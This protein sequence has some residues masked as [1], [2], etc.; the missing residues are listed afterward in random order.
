MDKSHKVNKYHVHL[1]HTRVEEWVEIIRSNK[2][3]MLTHSLQA[4]VC[5][6]IISNSNS[7]SNNNSNS[8]IINLSINMKWEIR[9]ENLLQSMPM[10]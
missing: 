9:D 8:N 4:L 5:Y 10:E 7:N 3:K 2:C 6:H 1:R